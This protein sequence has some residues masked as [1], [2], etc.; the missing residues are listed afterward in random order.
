MDRPVAARRSPIAFLLHGYLGVGKTTLARSLEVEHAAIRFTH[1]EWMRTLYG[2]DPPEAEFVH[3][4]QRVATL[5]E[6][7]WTRCL[8][9]GLD[10][11]L[12]LGFWSRAQRDRTR[13]LVRELGGECRLYRLTLPEEVARARVQRRNEGLNDS[14]FI[15][16]ATYE[17]LKARFEPLGTGEEHIDV[18]GAG[19]SHHDLTG[20]AS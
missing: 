15:A 18:P 7:T 4:A 13:A 19:G 3:Y 1:D 5:I 20:R 17:V 16:P 8:H 12:D 2:D 14:L 6:A 11:V 9:L 10:V